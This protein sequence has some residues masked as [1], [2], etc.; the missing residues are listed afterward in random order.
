MKEEREA[1][2]RREQEFYAT[3]SELLQIEHDYKVPF[4]KKTRWN[5]RVLGNGRFPGFGTIQYFGSFI[6][7]MCHK[8]TFQFN[9]FEEVY[10]FLRS[11][12]GALVKLGS[13]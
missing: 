1:R 7:V 11:N 10:D 6:R 8:G 3:C 12:M 13:R 9:K 4:R 5:N 2:I